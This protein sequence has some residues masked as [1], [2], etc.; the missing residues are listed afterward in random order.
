[1]IP[2]F[3]NEYFFLSNFYESPIEYNGMEYPSVEH[4]YQAQ[5]TLDI[6]ERFPFVCKDKSPAAAKKLGRKLTL[7]DDWEEVKERIMEE[8]VFI[9]FDTNEKLR[10]L[11]LSTGD[12]ELQEGN[13]WGDDYWGVCN[14]LGA[15]KLG[16][17]L[18]AVRELMKHKKDDT[19][20]EGS[21][22]VFKGP[23]DDISILKSDVEY[24]VWCLRQKDSKISSLEEEIK[25]KTNSNNQLPN[26]KMFFLAQ[27]Y[28]EDGRLIPLVNDRYKWSL[29]LWD[30]KEYA[31]KWRDENR[32]ELK[33]FEITDVEPER[34][35]FLSDKYK[36]TDE[37]EIK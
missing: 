10:L 19:K 4:A 29:D 1:M 24:L 14:G 3:K 23:I 21:I 28:K 34:R 11:L 31:Q 20:T 6:N 35:A 17:T 33:V 2:E 26:R 18:M 32:P 12:E 30:T 9:K 36:L 13:Y 5:K 37:K 8:L 7:R 22:G 16:K 25:D 27:F 15:N